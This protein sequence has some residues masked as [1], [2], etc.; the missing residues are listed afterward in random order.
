MDEITHSINPS[1]DVTFKGNLIC[2]EHTEKH[3]V[4]VLETSEYGRVLFLEN[5]PQS[6]DKDGDIYHFAAGRLIPI[7]ARVLV[8]GGGTLT[9]ITPYAKQDLRIRI[10]NHDPQ[11]TNVYA[12]HLPR[13]R[14]ALQEMQACNCDWKFIHGD[15]LQEVTRHAGSAYD[16]ILNDLP[17]LVDIYDDASSRRLIERLPGLLAPRG[18]TY[19]YLGTTTD[20]RVQQLRD[21]IRQAFNGHAIFHTSF[22]PLW[23]TESDFYEAW[24]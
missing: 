15:A 9:A 1:T 10:I 2:D 18:Y 4:R 6:S 21:A 17:S 14:E 20:P 3:R 11:D 24:K 19:G 7:N 12:A 13:V 16:I 8:L 23:M 5:D 22:V